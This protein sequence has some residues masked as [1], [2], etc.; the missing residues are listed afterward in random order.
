MALLRTSV[1]QL[2]ESSEVCCEI[3]ELLWQ[4]WIILFSM[5]IISFQKMADS[6]LEGELTVEDFLEK[7]VKERSELHVRRTKVDKLK[8]IMRHRNVLT[9]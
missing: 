6:F 8:E 7:Y 5:R 4:N 2:E 1:A 9:T 3:F